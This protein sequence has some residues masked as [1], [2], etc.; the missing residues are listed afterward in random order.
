M[1]WEKELNDIGKD[2]I[3]C[4]HSFTIKQD[5]FAKQHGRAEYNRKTSSIE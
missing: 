5:L 1:N 4:N 2:L 3:D